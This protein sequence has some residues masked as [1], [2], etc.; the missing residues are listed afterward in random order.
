MRRLARRAA[1][2]DS[3][4]GGVGGAGS[5]RQFR[6]EHDWQQ[7]CLRR[8]GGAGGTGGTGGA[9]GAGVPQMVG[10]SLPRLVAEAG[11]GTASTGYGGAAEPVGQP[12]SI[13]IGMAKGGD[14]D[15]GA[16]GGV[17]AV[18]VGRVVVVRAAPSHTGAMVVLVRRVRWRVV[19]G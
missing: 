18:L 16:F 8:Q 7:E 3:E 14:G 5:A 11:G 10:P 1:G 19:A 15:P 6:V 9:G 13:G 17:A 2:G 12:R 4:S